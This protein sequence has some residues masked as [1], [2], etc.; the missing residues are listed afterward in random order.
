MKQ[1]TKVIDKLVVKDMGSYT[2]YKY[3]KNYY[4]KPLENKKNF[5]LLNSRDSKYLRT[6]I[7]NDI[8]FGFLM[9]PLINNMFSVFQLKNYHFFI[10]WYKIPLNSNAK[11]WLYTSIDSQLSHV[12]LTFLNDVGITN[13]FSFK[14]KREKIERIDI[15]ESY[16]SFIIRQ[17]SF[18]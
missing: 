11:N 10:P 9:R 7:L 17:V 6:F 3:V 18:I 1:L 15:R 16:N 8:N 13:I 5:M 12:S 2:Y 14:D 4:C